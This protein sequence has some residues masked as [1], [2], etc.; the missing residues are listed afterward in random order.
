MSGPDDLDFGATRVG[1]KAGQK[2]FGRYSL[3]RILGRGG[4]GVVWLAR[5]EELESEVALKFLPELMT[6][7]KS[8]LDDLRKETRRSRELTHAN[9]VRIHDF[10]REDKWAAISMEFVDGDT[11]ANLRAAKEQ[12]RFEPGDLAEWTRQVCQALDYAHFDAKV[13][14]RDLKPANLMIDGK[15]RLKI[16]DF[17]ISR[18]VSDSLSKVS[19]QASTA[20]TPAYM[21]PQQMMGERPSPADD[22]YSLGATLYELL[23]GKPPFYAGNVIAQVQGKVP[24]SLKERRRELGTAGEPIPQNWE[25]AIAACLAKT[26][27]NRPK[28]A[29]ELAERLGV[30]GNAGIL[31]V[32]ETMP[33]TGSS[34][35]GGLPE[36]TTQPPP[37]LTETPTQPKSKKIQWFAIAG[38]M[39]VA[40]VV[41]YVLV[42]APER[43]RRAELEARLTAEKQAADLRAENERRNQK[44][45]DE[46]ELRRRQ[47]AEQAQKETEARLAA[48]ELE[49]KLNAAAALVVRTEPAG[50]EV[51]I[52]TAA[53]GVSPFRATALKLGRYTVRARLE[54]YEDFET[55]VELKRADV[56]DE[57]PVQLVRSTGR[58]EVTS[59]PAD[60]PFELVGRDYTRTGTTPAALDAVPAGPATLTVR[61]EGFS[62]QKKSVLIERGKE[63]TAAV[64]M[65]GGGLKVTS[66]PS[67][68]DVLSQGQ[69][70]G[71]TPLSLPE[72][73]PGTFVVRLQKKGYRE[74]EARVEVRAKE[75]AEA[76]V[77]LN[78]IVYPSANAAFENGLGMKF[79]PVPRMKVL[80]SVWLTRVK[81]FEAFV[82]ETKHD[83]NGRAEGVSSGFGS[84]AGLSWNAPGFNQGPTHPVC[85]ISWNDA[86]AFC[87]WMT[88]RDRR[89]DRIR[90]DQS[91]RLPTDEEWSAAS[92]DRGGYGSTPRDRANSS[93]NGFLHDLPAPSSGN[94]PGVEIRGANSFGYNPPFWAE[95]RDDYLQTSP[96]DAFPANKFGLHDMA[97]NLLQWCSDWFDQTPQNKT[98][99]G[100]A[101]AFWRAPGNALQQLM[102][103]ARGFADPAS[104]KVTFGFRCVLETK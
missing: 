58:I 95:H 18:S 67:G 52:G 12:K 83:M 89:E 57:L 31:G 24:P 64:E 104:R 63:S 59:A 94:F 35:S 3:V 85:A 48:A 5:D 87:R 22:I 62:A 20:G 9:I 6:E 74:G 14:H 27:A 103:G 15:G 45:A 50:A 1:L 66:T 81:D 100:S 53:T 56:V 26:V 2:V 7:D 77:Q 28:T 102:P 37:L 88:E 101:F 84:F 39:V 79:V 19:V 72:V 10:V 61:R 21:S 96:V 29:G 65:L 41:G 51:H 55:E 75:V 69:V 60:L 68:A 25:E 82:A 93:K 47:D 70:I 23:T 36:K 46:R 92:G 33:R 54:G 38:A 40:I 44:L 76:N 80:V 71:Q 99:R 43:E 32:G 13:V 11:L 73:V 90:A 91:Y 16:T 42:S 8:A 17:G 49:R 86:L 98:L 34:K 78:Q 97:G 30:G 4:M